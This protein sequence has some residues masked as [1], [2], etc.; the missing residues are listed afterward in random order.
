M[1]YKKLNN[2]KIFNLRT[3]QKTFSDLEIIA[4]NESRSVNE[5]IN[6]SVNEY[7]EKYKVNHPNL[8]KEFEVNEE[9]SN[10]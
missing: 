10:S 8:I 3:E 9:N 2:K 4:D 7:I 6:F 1:A 5:I